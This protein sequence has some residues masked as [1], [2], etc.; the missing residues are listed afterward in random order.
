[1]QTL[2]TLFKQ[3]KP[4][5]LLSFVEM[6]N[7]FS[8][9]GMRAL[10]VLFMVNA[11]HFDTSKALGVYAVFCALVELGAVFGGYLAEK[12]F[13]LRRAILL[14][15]W[16]VALGHLALAMEAFIPG[17]ALLI[18]GSS[19]FTSNLTALIGSCYE[20]GDE[21]RKEGFTLFYMS[22]NV[23]AL[24]AT[25]L[26]GLLAEKFGWSY[27]FGLAAFGMLL[28]NLALLRFR[29]LLKGRG[30]PPTCPRK[31]GGLFLL[32]GAMLAAL[33]LL[34]QK[35]TL[36]LLPFLAL[37]LGGGILKNL[38]KKGVALR[39]LVVSLAML[40]FFFAAEEQI[41]S[42]L[43][44]FADRMVSHRFLGMACSPSSI[45]AFNPV[46]IILCG[47]IATVVYR[48]LK[49]P[50][51]RVGIPFLPRSTRLGGFGPLSGFPKTPDSCTRDGSGRSD[52]VCRAPCRSHRL[53]LLLRGF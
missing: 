34:G 8:H 43:V 13:G 31:G 46:V 9:Y 53:C 25:L 29:S 11:L 18:L 27:G 15:G 30:E 26:C 38:R 22:I 47:A 17:L 36:P 6:W 19:L 20:K 41:G 44:L 33:C 21:R 51:L 32:A 39:P 35:V 7:R 4:V 49:G 40:I 52:F 48:I 23:G 2:T 14:G 50:A 16:I 45:M 1:M 37:A 3:P 28:G 24:I 42:S 5:F 12:I 10:L